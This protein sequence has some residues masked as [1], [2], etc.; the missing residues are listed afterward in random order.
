MFA[1]L[2]VT[3]GNE[4]TSYLPDTHELSIQP[5]ERGVHASLKSAMHDPCV[6]ELTMIFLIEA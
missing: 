1:V 3:H 5:G 2:C 4:Q 6:G